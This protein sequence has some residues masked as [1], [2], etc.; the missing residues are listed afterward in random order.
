[1]NDDTYD[2]MASQAYIAGRQAGKHG[3]SPSTNTY[4]VGSIEHIEWER[5]RMSAAVEPL[6]PINRKPCR[7]YKDLICYCDGKALC[8]DV[9]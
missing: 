5:G 2:A 7:Y 1:M 6:N 9:A 3:L 4:P 8:L